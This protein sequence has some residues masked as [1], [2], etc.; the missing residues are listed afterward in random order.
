MDTE[1]LKILKKATSNSFKANLANLRTFFQQILP[2]LSQLCEGITVMMP[3]ATELFKQVSQ[4]QLDPGLQTIKP[5]TFTQQVVTFTVIVT[6]ANWSF[7]ILLEILV[8]ITYDKIALLSDEIHDWTFGI[9][10]REGL[11]EV[12]LLP[13]EKHNRTFGIKVREVLPDEKHNRTFRIK[14]KE[15]L[16][17]EKHDQTFGIKCCQTKSMTRLLELSVAR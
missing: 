13:D 15:V 5:K 1:I 17:D 16:S 4:F 3:A 6:L 14:V 11:G 2:S 9:K 12:F 10:V 8:F 7:F